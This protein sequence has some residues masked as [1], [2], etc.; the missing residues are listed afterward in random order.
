MCIS[1]QS[2]KHASRLLEQQLNTMEE[3]LMQGQKKM[4][5]V[6]KEITELTSVTDETLSHKVQTLSDAC[7]VFMS[8]PHHS[9]ENNTTVCV[10]QWM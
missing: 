4:N 9:T 2:A 7:T 1:A 6:E 8:P 5:A 3:L 10:K